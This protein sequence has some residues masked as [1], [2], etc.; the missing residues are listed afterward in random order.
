MII[1][2][3]APKKGLGQTVTTVNLSARIASL[4]NHKVLMIDMNQYCIDIANYLSDTNWTRGLDEFKNLLDCGLLQDGDNLKKSIKPVHPL[5]DMMTSNHCFELSAL[6]LVRLGELVEGNYPITLFDTV[7]GNQEITKELVNKATVTVVVLN[8]EAR[9]I[10]MIHKYKLYQEQA[11]R[12]VFVVNRL[13]EEIQGQKV[14]YDLKKMKRE[15]KEIGFK[16]NEV[17]ALPFDINLWNECNERTLL[18]YSFPPR[19]HGVPYHRELEVLTKHLLTQYGNYSFETNSI[20]K[21]GIMKRKLLSLLQ[22]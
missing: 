6:D 2:V 21:D 15:L 8:Q 16:H 19:G 7:A 14:E 22:L 11:S 5:L 1:G 18:G 17:F 10:E 20:K 12:I 3:T 9:V 4:I 13:V